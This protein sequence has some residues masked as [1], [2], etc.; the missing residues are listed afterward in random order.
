MKKNLVL[1]AGRTGFFI[2]DYR[3]LASGRRVRPGV[4][5]FRGSP[6]IFYPVGKQFS[7]PRT[8]TWAKRC[9]VAES[10]PTNERRLATLGQSLDEIA[11]GKTNNK[12]VLSPGEEAFWDAIA[13]C[14]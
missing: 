7:I 2:A 4:I 12:E 10:L 8:T 13:D 9:G 3:G 5:R 6:V 14:G 1:P 11:I